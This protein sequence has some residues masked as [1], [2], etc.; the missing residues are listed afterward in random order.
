MAVDFFITQGDLAQSFV[1]QL[2]RADGSLPDLTGASVFFRYRNLDNDAGP[3]VIA[4]ASIVGVPTNAT[5][6]YD[7]QTADT[8]TPGVLLADWKVVYV[9]GKTESFPSGRV[10]RIKIK[11]KP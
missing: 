2:S 10:L 11:A 3:E 1:Q 5:V 7:W 4:A 8:A 9:G 6:Q